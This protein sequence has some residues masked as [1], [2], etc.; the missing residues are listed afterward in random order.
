M[1]S[2]LLVSLCLGLGL[3]ACCGF[4]VF[5]PLLATNVAALLHIVT[6]GEGFVWLGT[7]TALACL[8][9]ATVGEILAYYVPFI[10]NLLDG[11][12]TPVSVVAGTLISTSI[13]PIDEPLLKWALGLMVGGGSAAVIQTGTGILRLLSSKLTGGTANSI[14]STT[15]NAA[16][17]GGS[18]FVFFMPFAV[19]GLFL[20]LIVW[21]LNRLFKKKSSSGI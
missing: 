8:L 6:L 14:V 4:R 9:A 15:E 13:L 20:C 5:I 17:I 7:Y 10:D 16:A 3:S 18:L 1:N 21:L 2:D 12:A 19:S 11:I